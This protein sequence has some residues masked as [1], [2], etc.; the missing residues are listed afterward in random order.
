MSEPPSSYQRYSVMDSR[1]DHPYIAERVRDLSFQRSPSFD[2][3]AGDNILHVT[4]MDGIEH[5]KSPLDRSFS[6][7]HSLQQINRPCGVSLNDLYRAVLLVN[8]H[9]GKPE[10][11]DVIMKDLSLKVTIPPKI[12]KIEKK[13]AKAKE[14]ERR[15][16]EVRKRNRTTWWQS[17]SAS[18]EISESIE[19][20]QQ[21]ISKI[22]G[23]ESEH[24]SHSS[25]E[26]SNPPNTSD[27]HD[28][29]DLSDSS[30]GEVLEKVLSSPHCHS[31]ELE[32]E[33]LF[34]DTRESAIGDMTAKDERKQRKQ[35][36]SAHK[37]QHILKSVSFEA[38]Q[39]ELLAIIG[40]SGSGK[41]SLLACICGDVKYPLLT[42]SALIFGHKP[43]RWMRRYLGIVKQND[44]HVPTDTVR[45]AVK[46][47]CCCRV[48]GTA[49]EI[50]S[51]TDTVLK[52]LSLNHISH[53]IIGGTESESATSTSSTVSGGERRR[54]SIGVEL[55]VNPTILLA[56][57][58]TSG[59]D[60]ATADRFVVLLR[61]L[62]G[63]DTVGS[64]LE[65]I[66]SID[67]IESVEIVDGE[68]RIGKH[69]RVII[70]TIHRPSS[71]QFALLERLLVMM[72]GEV[73]F[74][75]Y[76]SD[77]EEYFSLIGFPVPK[78]HHIN[79]CDHIIDVVSKD[80]L[81]EPTFSQSYV[82]RKR[83][84]SHLASCA[85]A[86]RYGMLF[87]D[88]VGGVFPPSNPIFISNPQDPSM[89]DQGSAGR[90]SSL[91]SDT[92]IIDDTSSL[93]L[94]EDVTTD[95]RKSLD[96]E[97]KHPGK[98]CPK[99][100]AKLTEEDEEDEG[101]LAHMVSPPTKECIN[102]EYHSN[103]PERIPRDYQSKTAPVKMKSPASSS[104]SFQFV[105]ASV[106]AF[107]QPVTGDP[108]NQLSKYSPNQQQDK[109]S[110]PSWH[111]MK[112]HSFKYTRGFWSQLFLLLHRMYTRFM[113]D[114]SLAIFLI[115]QYTFLGLFVGSLWFQ[116]GYDQQSVQTRNVVL[117]FSS[118]LFLFL[119]V[120]NSS[121]MFS[122]DRAIYQREYSNGCYCT[123]A[124]YLH[125]FLAF[126]PADFLMAVLF[127]SISFWMVDLSPF[128]SS[129]V[130]YTLNAF[131]GIQ[132]ARSFAIA[133]TSLVRDVRTAQILAGI[134]LTLFFTQGIMF[135]SMDVSGMWMWLRYI[136]FFRFAILNAQII[137][138]TDLEFTCP[139]N[140]PGTCAINTGAD[141]LHYFGLENISSSTVTAYFFILFAILNAQIIVFTD[142]EFTC[143]PNPPGTCAINTGADALHYFG[144]EN[145]SSS[146][147]T[148]YFFILLG[149]FLIYFF[150]GFL[151][152]RY[153]KFSQYK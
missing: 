55:V 65:H 62:A 16:L 67:S 1:V 146:T 143:P 118:T 26:I 58:P 36:E 9:L 150:A 23:E 34:V 116:I 18:S 141:A 33:N 8:S 86:L 31:T 103:P 88:M 135:A 71:S 130:L 136:S 144:L 22:K 137:V 112:V 83:Y 59:I 13:L 106:S 142:L 29:Q 139:P 98:D 74:F 70:T 69:K 97:T 109:D 52:V 123:F 95:L 145:I 87:D 147:V 14:K 6:L 120:Y 91:K 101:S 138:F 20:Q 113:R 63:G 5:Q 126:I 111:R 127:I 38:K 78:D 82:D 40:P 84:L 60:S 45:E 35:K 115:L 57:E 114:P 48:G 39:G 64:M 66:G 30:A 37:Y 81:K 104:T 129:Y 107:S 2:S 4:M 27:I 79:V 3:S 125:F 100:C 43:G 108:K 92:T 85:K 54:V 122:L 76:V 7:F 11:C 132:V 53:H 134:T 80:S 25:L 50:D 47:S 124:Y 128:F 149:M 90:S 49:E 19:K 89:K 148:A 94:T 121:L 42:G 99:D 41:S 15:D 24:I 72:E 117:F 105:S 28:T 93:K 56:D 77:V 110:S 51:T 119:P 140:P 152:L 21:N 73:A 68:R 153:R 32:E 44:A 133:V 102:P 46:F 75:G 12:R 17:H 131:M 10:H 151:G 96:D 61:R